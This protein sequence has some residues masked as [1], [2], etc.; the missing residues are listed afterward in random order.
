MH[1]LLVAGDIHYY[2]SASNFNFALNTGRLDELLRQ[3]MTD[4]QEHGAGAMKLKFEV[5]LVNECCGHTKSINGL[6]TILHKDKDAPLD[7][8][9]WWFNNAIEHIRDTEIIMIRFHETNPQEVLNDE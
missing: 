6:T 7:G 1:E 3:N 2:G 5:L 4:A 9:Y 8:A